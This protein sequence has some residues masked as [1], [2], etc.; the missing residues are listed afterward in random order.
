MKAHE[1]LL[2]GRPPV[3]EAEAERW[4]EWATE[5][6]AN[7]RTGL[8]LTDAATR[9]DYPGTDQ[10]WARLVD[11]EQRMR[12]L[13]G[14]GR[15]VEEPEWASRSK[16][17]DA[18]RNPDKAPAWLKATDAWDRAMRWAAD[19]LSDS[20][21]A[22]GLLILGPTGTGKTGI[23][24]AIAAMCDEPERC[25]YWPVRALLTAAKADFLDHRETTLDAARRTPLLVLDD[26]GVERK[27]DWNVDTLGELVEHRHAHGRRLVITSNLRRDDLRRHLST[28]GHERT[29]SRLVEVTETVVLD[30]QDRRREA[31]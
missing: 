31:A 30:G 15:N 29:F 22:K 3:D 6:T 8:W 1:V 4:R 13:V 7:V 2:D 11:I 18:Y 19:W 10:G 9:A 23:A 27:T 24:T 17:P 28:A 5:C 12:R 21:P 26:L 25:A 14:K 16:I 20:R